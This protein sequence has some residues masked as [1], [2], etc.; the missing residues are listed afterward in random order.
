MK[1]SIKNIF[2]KCFVITFIFCC[3]VTMLYYLLPQSYNKCWGTYGIVEMN[4]TKILKGI[5]LGGE[6]KVLAIEE[7]DKQNQI[8]LEA[9]RKLGKSPY[10]LFLPE[11]LL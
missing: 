10:T 5:K 8:Q 3:L 11:S 6:A 7:M 9:C 2:K 1:L 4:Y